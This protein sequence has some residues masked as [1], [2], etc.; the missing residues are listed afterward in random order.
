MHT[1]V[2]KRKLVLVLVLRSRG[3]TRLT[4]W[5]Y[6]NT[7][8]SLACAVT[9]VVLLPVPAAGSRRG[10]KP[11]SSTRGAV[12]SAEVG[13]AEENGLEYCFAFSYAI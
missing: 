8:A 10:W 7:R 9:R 2:R 13:F 4:A 5:T 1:V 11:G 6:D 3:T 12:G